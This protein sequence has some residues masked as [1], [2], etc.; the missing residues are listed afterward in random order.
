MKI[1]LSFQSSS[2]KSS[3][4]DYVKTVDDH[5]DAALKTILRNHPDINVI[6]ANRGGKCLTSTLTKKQALESCG[7]ILNFTDK[8]K[9]TIRKLFNEELTHVRIKGRRNEIIV[10]FDDLLEIITLKEDEQ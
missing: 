6:I 4:K 1:F 10:M 3:K 7:C 8:A 9:L 2:E 5:A